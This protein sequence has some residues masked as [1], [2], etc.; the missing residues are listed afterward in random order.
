MKLHSRAVIRRRRTVL[1]IL[2]ILPLMACSRKDTKPTF[3]GTD[4]SEVPWGRDFQLLDVDGAPRSVADYRGKVVMLFFGFTHC[5][6]VC[7]LTLAKM[8]QAVREIGEEGARVQGIFVTLDPARDT[9]AV[10]ARYV[11]AFHP[12]FVGL[13]ADPAVIEATAANFKLFFERQRPDEHGAYSV[14]HQGAIYVFDRHG[15][16][17][18]YFSADAPVEA[19]VHDIKVLL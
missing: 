17:R 10:L 12:S 4:I 6:D 13:S 8:G 1:A 9:P 3:A 18:L 2:G 15:Q 7:P 14:D 11:P 5:P 19:L 16:L